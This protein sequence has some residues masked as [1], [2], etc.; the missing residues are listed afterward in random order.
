MDME[1][2]AGSEFMEFLR[3][4]RELIARLAYLVWN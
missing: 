4:V 2:K 1:G 3:F